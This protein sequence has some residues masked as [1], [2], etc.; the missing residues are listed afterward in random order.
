MHK[1]TISHE[2]APMWNAWLVVCFCL[3]IDPPLPNPVF[4]EILKNNTSS[5]LSKYTYLTSLRF[6]GKQK[7]C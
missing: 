6:K 7:R 5:F 3:A 1:Q 2:N 4:V